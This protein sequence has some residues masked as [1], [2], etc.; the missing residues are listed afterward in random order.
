MTEETLDLH[1]KRFHTPSLLFWDVT[2]ETLDLHLKRFQTPSQA[3]KDIFSRIQ[4]YQD[5]AKDP[6]VKM[7]LWRTLRTVQPN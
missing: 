5:L 3:T 2:E 1:L 7:E 6:P 4:Q